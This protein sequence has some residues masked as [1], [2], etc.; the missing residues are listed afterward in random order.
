MFNCTAMTLE[1]EKFFVWRKNLI[2][3]SGIARQEQGAQPP[4]FQTKRKHRGPTFKLHEIGQFGQYKINII[5]IVATK[6]HFYAQKQLLLSPRFSHRN[7]VC[8]SV[9]SSVTRVD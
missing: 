9:C 4:I 6:T 8:P 5:K 3:S 2:N 1:K 7:S